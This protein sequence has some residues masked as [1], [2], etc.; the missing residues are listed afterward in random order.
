MQNPQCSLLWLA[1]MRE[2]TGHNGVQCEREG[3][4]PMTREQATE[5][6][7]LTAA[8]IALLERAQA[9]RK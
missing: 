1:A 2:L 4:E 5:L 7:T 3:T 9:W 6:A 8:E